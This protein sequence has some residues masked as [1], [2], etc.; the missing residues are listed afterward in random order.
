M[1]NLKEHTGKLGSAPPS[2]W[3]VTDGRWS[4]DC[5]AQWMK[6]AVDF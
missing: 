1:K 2:P 4:E 6:M 5:A 3:V